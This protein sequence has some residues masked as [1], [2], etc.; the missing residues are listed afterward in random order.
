MFLN[1]MTGNRGKSSQYTMHVYM[2]MYSSQG[3]AS[4]V[5]Q[6][7]RILL[8]YGLI[9]FN[10]WTYKNGLIIKF[11]FFNVCLHVCAVF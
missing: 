6:L 11:C 2:S 9:V 4:S 7:F 10:V 5:H 3:W 1:G 8:L